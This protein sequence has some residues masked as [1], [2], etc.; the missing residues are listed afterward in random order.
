M[1]VAAYIDGFNLYHA[2]EALGDPL[3]KWCNL[4]ALAESFIREDETLQRVVFYTAY[5]TWDADKRRRHLNY[6]KAL[7]A[8][9]VEVRRSNF[10]KVDKLCEKFGRRCSFFEEKKTDVALATDMLS[11]CYER[12]IERTLLFSA[13]S[14]QV[15]AVEHIRR[16]FPRN[17][18][19]MIAPP[20]RLSQARE[21]SAACTSFAELSAGR[22]R[23]C[24]L[25]HDVRDG[26][27]RLVAACPSRYGPH[28]P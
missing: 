14:D 21:L 15:P 2:V 17:K 25:P 10:S 24:A 27:G 23:Q 7:E 8:T 1:R 9:G 3:L 28:R 5:N 13:D 16:R 19:H 18:I 20:G 12:A 6:V 11:D 22:L 26:R 4:R